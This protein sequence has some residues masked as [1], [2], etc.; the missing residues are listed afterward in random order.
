MFSPNFLFTFVLM[1]GLNLS[2]AALAHEFCVG[3]AENIY[4][5][6]RNFDTL[7]AENYERFWDILHKAVATA[8]RCNSQQN[9]VGFL[10][11]SSLK[12]DNAE[13]N[14]FFSQ[15]LEEFCLQK[16]IC[17]SRGVSKLDKKARDLL[18]E[19]LKRPLFVDEAAI[20]KAKC[21]PGG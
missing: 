3:K 20:M 9:V 13:F 5:L 16:P 12:T 2:K 7:Y 1:V 4:C 10:R 15:S 14:E 11:L 19:K 18:K 21:F 8:K 6:E 17:F